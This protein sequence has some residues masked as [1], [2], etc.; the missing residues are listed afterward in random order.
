MKMNITEL[1]NKEIDRLISF[2]IWYT[3]NSDKNPSDFPDEMNDADF[4]EQ[5]A[6]FNPADDL[7]SVPKSYQ[8][9]QFD[10]DQIRADLKHQL[11]I[12]DEIDWDYFLETTIRAKIKADATNKNMTL[13]KK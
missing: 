13:D 7:F 10:L 12:P 3:Y 1:F 6:M 4:H 5:L 2:C 8:F 11:S 9:E